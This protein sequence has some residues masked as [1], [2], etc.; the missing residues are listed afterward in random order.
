MAH[1]GHHHGPHDHH[2]HH[3]HAHAPIGHN[4]ATATTQWQTPHLPEGEARPEAAPSEPDLDLVETA[5][6]EAFPRAPDPTSF[7]R[8]AGV[9]FIGRTTDGRTLNLLRVEASQTTD[10]GSVTPH[11]GGEGF[12]YTPLPAAITSRRDALAFVYQSDDQTVRLA[13]SEAKAL[14]NVTPSR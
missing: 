8:L 10:V 2:H 9:P 1:D 14:T 4:G 11:L 13:L 5:F 3:H 12:N 6:L 7:L